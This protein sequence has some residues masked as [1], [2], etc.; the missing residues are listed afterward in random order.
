MSD[1]RR[2]NPAKAQR[3]NSGR[4]RITRIGP[5]EITT[6]AVG[7]KN[8]SGRCGFFVDEIRV[9]SLILGHLELRFFRVF[10]L[11]RGLFDV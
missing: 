5:N 1:D 9:R 8:R 10:P 3:R 11:V 7:A 6:S 2:K 4:A